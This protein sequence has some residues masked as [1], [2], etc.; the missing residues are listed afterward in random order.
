MEPQIIATEA[1]LVLLRLVL[2]GR[3]ARSSHSAQELFVYKAGGPQGQ[4]PPSL[5][6]IPRLSGRFLGIWGGGEPV[7]LLKLHDDTAEY[8]VAALCDDDKSQFEVC[9]FHSKDKVWTTRPVA[10]PRRDDDSFRHETTTVITVGGERGTMAFVDLWRGI[11]LYDV[12]AG[13]DDDPTLP[14]C[15]P[16][17]E[18]IFGTPCYSVNPLI[19]RDIAVVN[20][21]FKYVEMGSEVTAD[22]ASRGPMIA[23]HSMPIASCRQEEDASWR[24]DCKIDVSKIRDDKNL[25]SPEVQRMLSYDERMTKPEP[26]LETLCTGHPTLCLHDEDTVYFTTMAKPMSPKACVVAVNIRERTI[27]GVA[28]FGARTRGI[29]FTFIRSRIYSYLNMTPEVRKSVGFKKKTKGTKVMEFGL[30]IPRF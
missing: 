16:L 11:L 24:R 7:G 6:Q 15:V 25:L 1:D 3:S 14:R 23:A 12:L 21:Q 19:Y 9:L 26:T 4:P 28:R 13:D 17:P 27:Q 20:G 18:T 10:V 29:N 2:G 30:A 5:E 8:I 22:K